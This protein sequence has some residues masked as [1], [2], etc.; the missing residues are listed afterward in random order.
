MFWEILQELSSEK[1]LLFYKFCT[2]GTRIPIDGFNAL[3]GTR[4]KYQKFCIE[5]P[6]LDEKNMKRL[7]EAKTCFNRIYLPDYET[8]EGLRN[9][10]DLILENDT[11]F[12]GKQ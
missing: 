6:A 12:F 5:S 11:N 7:I 2:G 10:I 9:V 4:N 8:K 3:Q 1:L